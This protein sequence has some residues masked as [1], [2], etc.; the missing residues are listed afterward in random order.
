MKI[1]YTLSSDEALQIATEFLRRKRK[2]GRQRRIL[3]LLSV[4][5][6]AAFAASDPATISIGE[7]PS[8][9]FSLLLTVLVQIPIMA[10]LFWLALKVLMYPFTSWY[11][12]VLRKT[13]AD[14]PFEHWGNRRFELADGQVKVSTDIGSTSLKAS[15]IEGI[16]TTEHGYHLVRKDTPQFMVPVKICDAGH[17]REALE[18]ESGAPVVEF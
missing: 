5:F 4:A 17:L 9:G 2:P 12:R 14:Q 11:E 13:I 7:N 18:R 3:I 10:I 6:A 15:L 16:V 1:D 8:A